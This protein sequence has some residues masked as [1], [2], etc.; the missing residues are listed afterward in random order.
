MPVA[1]R[2]LQIFW[3]C[4]LLL[5]LPQCSSESGDNNQEGWEHLDHDEHVSAEASFKKALEENPKN[6]DAHYGLGSVYS[7]QKKLDEA[8]A[9]YK[10]AVR[11]DPTHFDAHYG[12]GYIYEQ[13]GDKEA[14]ERQYARYRRLKKKMDQMREEA[15]KP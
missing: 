3:L 6:S 8:E 14:A 13:K 5:I 2:I 10:K 4:T 12:L 9:A 1:S 15:G 11:L 7:A